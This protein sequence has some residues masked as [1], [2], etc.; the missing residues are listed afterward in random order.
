ML[1]VLKKPEIRVTNEIKLLQVIFGFVLLTIF[2]EIYDPHNL[3]AAE[4]FLI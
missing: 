1:N 4:S 2:R 3:S